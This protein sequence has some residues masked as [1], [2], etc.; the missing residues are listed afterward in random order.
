MSKFEDKAKELFNDIQFYCTE[1]DKEF[2]FG[3]INMKKSFIKLLEDYVVDL[4]KEIE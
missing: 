1:E 3:S 4:K 2:I